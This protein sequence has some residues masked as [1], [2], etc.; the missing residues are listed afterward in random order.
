MPLSSWLIG[1]MAG[2]GLQ[3]FGAGNT[4]TFNNP[5]YLWT[6]PGGSN[7]LC[8][9]LVSTVS[10][11]TDCYLTQSGYVHIDGTG[12]IDWT[13]ATEWRDALGFTGA[14]DL[15]GLGGATA[16]N[17]SPLLW[18][19]RAV[20]SP[21]K[22]IIRGE[23]ALE[24]RSVTHKSVDGTQNYRAFADP[25]RVEKWKW[26]YIA[27]DQYWTLEENDGEL[28]QFARDIL[29]PRWSFYLYPRR[30]ADPDSEDE[31]LLDGG[32]GPYRADGKNVATLI[33]RIA[34][35]FANRECRFDFTLSAISTPEYEQ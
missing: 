25:I 2:I 20:E 26:R 12:T 17:R 31:V 29:G 32:V 4:H 27:P 9:Q 18:V 24:H 23:G 34:Q 8:R 14:S 33:K 35:G 16:P 15:I 28:F 6:P 30:Q 22:G 19:P 21:E 5:V 7:D 3:D 1:S 11:V 10:N 13:S